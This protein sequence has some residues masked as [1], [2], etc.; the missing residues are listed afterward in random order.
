MQG[1][2]ELDHAQPGAEVAA[3]NRYCV[4]R[5]RPQLVANL[6][7]LALG[8]AAEILRGADCIEERCR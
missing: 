4:D 1:H 8:Q 6:P 2:R 7:E 3:G 5:L